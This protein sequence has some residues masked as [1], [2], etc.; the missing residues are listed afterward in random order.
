MTKNPSERTSLRARALRLLARREHSRLEL[1]RKLAAHAASPEALDELLTDFVQR[2]WLD[3]SRV[4]TS[5]LHRQA[6]RLGNQRIRQAL[7]Q[8]GL[9]DE[10]IA[11][12]CALLAPTE[13]QRAQDVLGR[14][15]PNPPITAQ[16]HSRQYR[17]LQ[18]RGF[19]AESI[20]QALRHR[21][22]TGDDQLA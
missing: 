18:A 2:G 10:L 22:S 20:R 3:E 7:Q 13:V 9:P 6:P 1:R 19:S 5:V 15:F 12:S 16:E 11:E 17:F 4:A 8:L 21:P 14:K